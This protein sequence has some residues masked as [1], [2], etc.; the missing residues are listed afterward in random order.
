MADSTNKRLRDLSR[1]IRDGGG[2]VDEIIK[3]KHIKVRFTNPHGVR[4]TL[5]LPV[6]P[7]DHRGPKDNMM[8]LRRLMQAQSPVRFVA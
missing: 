8:F 1:A 5:I 3:N 4:Q 7:G 6:S 2:H